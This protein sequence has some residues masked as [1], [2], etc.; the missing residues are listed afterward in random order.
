MYNTRDLD[1]S[2]EER[3]K[4]EYLAELN[5]LKNQ[6]RRV[7]RQM[8]IKTPSNKMFAKE[9]PLFKKACERAEIPP[10][11]RQASKYRNKQGKAYNLK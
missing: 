10:T 1:P 4:R 3:K 5:I 6:T 7:C 2:E 11:I 8:Y 9:S